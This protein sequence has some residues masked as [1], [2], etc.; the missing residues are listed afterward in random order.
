MQDWR[1]LY[2]SKT[3]SKTLLRLLIIPRVLHETIVH[4]DLRMCYGSFSFAGLK[5]KKK[6]PTVHQFKPWF[7]PVLSPT[8]C[9]DSDSLH[10]IFCILCGVSPALADS[11]GLLEPKPNGQLSYVPQ[12]CRGGRTSLPCQQAQQSILRSL[13]VPPG[14]LVP[15]WRGQPLHRGQCVLLRIHSRSV[16]RSAN[17]IFFFFLHKEKRLVDVILMVNGENLCHLIVDVSGYLF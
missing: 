9:I 3:S 1:P 16:C 11:L 2:R 12:P 13:C 4:S 8:Q 5:K 15:P 14:P 10:L 6:L 7:N 17:F